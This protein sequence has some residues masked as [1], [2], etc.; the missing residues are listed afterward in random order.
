[1]NASKKCPALQN[2][3]DDFADYLKINKAIQLYFFQ[4]QR[5]QENYLLFSFD[6]YDLSEVSKKIALSKDFVLSILIKYFKREWRRLL[7]NEN[8]FGL[9][10]LQ[11]YVASLMIK[12]ELFTANAYLPK[13]NQLLGFRNNNQAMGIFHQQ[14]EGFNGQDLLW[15]LAKRYI[16]FQKLASNIPEIKEGPGRNVQYPLS[17][18]LLNR[19]DLLSFASYFLEKNLRPDEELSLVEFEKIIEFSKIC[20]NNKITRHAR[21]I[22][23]EYDS[24]KTLEIILLQIFNFY[25]TWDGTI[26]SIQTSDKQYIEKAPFSLLLV[27]EEAA[28]FYF[29]LNKNHDQ[30]YQLNKQFFKKLKQLQHKT[31]QKKL[32]LFRNISPY[33]DDYEEVRLAGIGERIVLIFDVDTYP[34]LVSDLCDKEDKIRMG[35][36]QII[37]FTIT[38][39][40]AKLP[41]FRRFIQ[42]Y[43]LRLREGFESWLDKYLVRKCWPNCRN[44]RR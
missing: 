13:L 7:T 18:S 31:F 8:Y 29:Y 43:K 44:S 42:N 33:P 28:S 22:I 12:D 23:K 9:I 27:E 39:N 41:Y 15:A 20:N 35:A 34:F 19:Q 38:E 11:C 10:A 2:D 32:V 1:M 25:Q 40:D 24:T 5:I 36:I 17:Q 30:P 37:K 16:K 4:S 3:S 14:I 6:E 26:S 21:K